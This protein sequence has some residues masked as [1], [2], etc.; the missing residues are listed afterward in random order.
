MQ[1]DLF[2][3]TGMN[4]RPKFSYYHHQ[5]GLELHSDSICPLSL[6]QR[7]LLHLPSLPSHSVPHAFLTEASV[8]QK[9]AKVVQGE[10]EA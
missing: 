9:D 5:F 10:D 1:C 7:L 6:D 4:S 3:E 2:P 8:P